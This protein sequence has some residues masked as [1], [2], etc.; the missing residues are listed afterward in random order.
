M[1]KIKRTLF[2]HIKEQDFVKFMFI[3]PEQIQRFSGNIAVRAFNHILPPSKKFLRETFNAL[4]NNKILSQ[5]SLVPDNFSNTRFQISSLK[6]REGSEFVA[7]PLIDYV[8]NKF[9]GNGATS[10][11]VYV[12]E[13]APQIISLF[14]N[15]CGF[16]SCAKVEFYQTEDLKTEEN[17]F[18]E[19]NFRDLKDSDILELLEINTLN[20]APHFRPALISKLKTFKRKFLKHTKNDFFKV[21]VVNSSPEGYFRVYTTDGENFVADIITSKPYEQCYAEMISYIKHS[22]SKNKK[23]KTLTVL[24][25]RYRETSKALEDILNNTDFKL[26]NVTQVLIKDYWHRVSE[27]QFEEKF[28]VFFNDL[29]AQPARY[30][31]FML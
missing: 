19:K 12:D 7:K 6:I 29:T 21:F 13:N 27:S 3:N 4:E 26:T 2:D 16:R 23:F 30:N 10:F 31:S 25:K 9:G 5:L 17:S 1:L 8:V 14:K 15:E 18:N 20:I 11:M 24:L 22:L 28:L